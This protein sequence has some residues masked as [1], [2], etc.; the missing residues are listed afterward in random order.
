M[1]LYFNSTNPKHT[2]IALTINYAELVAKRDLLWRNSYCVYV[3]GGKVWKQTQGLPEHSHR[4]PNPEPE[5][6]A[7]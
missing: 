5:A 2:T 3:R 1:T 4:E 7:R 6:G